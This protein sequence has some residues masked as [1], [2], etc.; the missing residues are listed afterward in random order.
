ML[1]DRYA[2]EDVFARAPEVAEQTDPFSKPW[3]P[4]AGYWWTVYESSAGICG[5]P[6]H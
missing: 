3:I 6:N 1:V 4:T 5:G 2:P